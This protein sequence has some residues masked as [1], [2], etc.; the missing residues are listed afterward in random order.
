MK[1]LLFIV[2]VFLLASCSQ[3]KEKQGNST[4]STS[5]KPTG[6]TEIAFNEKI[7]DFGTLVSGEIV[8]ST[9]TFTNSGKQNL[10]IKNINAGCGCLQVKYP[11]TTVKPGETGLIEVEFDSSGMF[12]R[13][14]KTIEIDANCKEPK[15]LAIFAIVKNENLEIKY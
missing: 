1:R 6:I 14:Y 15:H 13:Q 5:E 10:I 2:S 9:F 3:K 11:K 12:G 4:N 8:V 7:H